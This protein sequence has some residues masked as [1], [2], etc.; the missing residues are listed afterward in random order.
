M[1][2][3]FFATAKA[4]GAVLLNY[5]DVTDL[6][7]AG[8]VVTGARVR[9][10]VTGRETTIGADLVV[11]ATGPWS[12]QV[13]HMAGVDV[14]IRPSPGV[15]L[16]VRGRLCNMVVNR[17]HASGDGDI[18]VPQRALSVV[19]T[20]SWVVEDPDDL[21]VPAGPRPTHD[22]RGIDVDPRRP[23]RAV[24]LGV[25]G[26]PAADRLEG[27]RRLGTRALAD[28]QDDRPRAWT[29]AS[30]GSS[31]SPAAR[32]RPCA[33]WPRCA[34]TWSC[35]KLGRRRTLPHAR[36]RPAPPHGGLRR[37]SAEDARSRTAA[38]GPRRFRVHRF[39]RDG[40]P[41]HV[42]EHDVPVEDRTTVLEALRWIQ[43]HRDRTL[44][45]RHSCFHAS[46][47]TCGV[48]VN[49]RERLACVTPLAE[50][51]GSHGHR[52]AHREPAGAERPRRRHDVVRRD[53]SPRP[54]RIVRES[55][56]LPEAEMPDDL[57]GFVRFEDCIE[58]GLCLSACPV[59]ATDDTLRR[60]R[61]PRLRPADAGGGPRHA[62][63]ATRC[64]TGRIR[65][66]P[67]GAATPRSNAPRPAPPTCVPPSGS[68]PCA[69]SFAA[70]ARPGTGGP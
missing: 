66:S 60:A 69:R 33:A 12:E 34:P 55:E 28:L 11:N 65:T 58:C 61:G 47:G 68:W 17:L 14:P 3:R 43:L 4:N 40:S 32:A 44:A 30:R 23:R 38:Q 49:G 53:G 63:T 7:R 56:F 48:R 45:L 42:E 6:E 9:D 16:A 54:M 8:G 19:G 2:L 59:A 52:R 25:V 46:C 36:D 22:R 24:P 5:V 50:V 31:R 29:T 64:W 18:V 41:A 13:A 35:R 15:M 57:G 21:G 67:P 37:M 10:V 27:R 1:P 62:S 20:S 26:R 70:A 39:K 51:S